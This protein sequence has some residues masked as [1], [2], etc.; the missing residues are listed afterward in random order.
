MKFVDRAKE[1]LIFLGKGLAVF[2]GAVFIHTTLHEWLHW[3][4]AY[5]L[6]LHPSDITLQ[7]FVG[8]YLEFQLIY[9]QAVFPILMPL[10]AL[11]TVGWYLI[12]TGFEKYSLARVAVGG[13][14]LVHELIYQFGFSTSDFNLLCTEHKLIGI[15]ILLELLLI[16]TI[17]ARANK[18]NAGR[19]SVLRGIL[20]RIRAI[21]LPEKILKRRE[22]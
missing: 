1:A 11:G 5:L 20:H 8:G 15:M 6:G 17:V 7:P 14:L 18:K 22:R 21:R 4:P 2:A 13:E 19:P 10:L 9:P 12:L 16:G 3:I